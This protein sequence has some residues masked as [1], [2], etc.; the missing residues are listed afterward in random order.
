MTAVA[1]TPERT[2]RPVQVADPSNTLPGELNDA[3]LA[4]ARIYHELPALWLGP[5][6][7]GLNLVA[8]MRSAVSIPW[9]FAIGFLA[10]FAT[11]G[12]VVFGFA[13]VSVASGWRNDEWG[14]D[15][16]AFNGEATLLGTTI[17]VVVGAAGHLF[18]SRWRSVHLLLVAA[19]GA[20]V[21]GVLHGAATAAGPTVAGVAMVSPG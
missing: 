3:A 19:A 4:D 7:N 9:V 10:E 8:F 5:A 1:S 17:F 11:I 13:L 14:A 16:W 2:A 20:M 15:G 18:L 6:F 12:A 21:A